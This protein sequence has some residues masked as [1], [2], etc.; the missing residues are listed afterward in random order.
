MLRSMWTSLALTLLCALALRT[1][2]DVVNLTDEDFA[3]VVDGSK[4]VLVEF[5][6]PWCGHCKNLAPEWK[7]AGETFQPSDDIV[8]AAVDATVATASAGK[9]GVKG[10]PTIKYFAKGET[11]PE[12]YKGGRTAADIVKWVNEKVGTNRRVKTVPSD[13]T[14]LTS[15]N[16]D[17][18]TG[19]KAALVEF[20]APWC[21]HCKTLAPKYEKLAKV[22]A[23]LQHPNAETTNF[24]N[25]LGT[26]TFSNLYI[27]V[28]FPQSLNITTINVLY[29]LYCANR[30]RISLQ[31]D[32]RY[33]LHAIIQLFQFLRRRQSSRLNLIHRI[34][35]PIPSPPKFSVAHTHTP[36]ASSASLCVGG[37]GSSPT[38]RV[39]VIPIYPTQPSYHGFIFHGYSHDK[40]I[41]L[42]IDEK[43]STSTDAGLLLSSLQHIYSKSMS[44]NQ[45]PSSTVDQIANFISDS[46]ILQFS[47]ETNRALY[48]FTTPNGLCGYFALYQ[49]YMRSS[50]RFTKSRD[51]V[52]SPNL[53][54]PYEQRLFTSFISTLAS[55]SP[56]KEFKEAIR[57]VLS[58][59]TVSFS[60][61][62]NNSHAFYN[63]HSNWL[64][65]SWL[66]DIPMQFE[67]S[68]FSDTTSIPLFGKQNEG[69]SYF[70]TLSYSS[71]FGNTFKYSLKELKTI[72]GK[73]NY[74]QHSQNHYFLMTSPKPSEEI[75]RLN[76]ALFDLSEVIFKYLQNSNDNINYPHHTLQPDPATETQPYSHT[77]SE[78]TCINL[79]TKLLDL[80]FDQHG[81]LVSLPN[82]ISFIPK[83]FIPKIRKLFNI[84][85]ETVIAYPHNDLNWKKFLLL[86]TVLFTLPKPN[87]NS[88]L[89]TRLNLL[90]D[91]DWSRFSFGSLGIS[92]Y[93]NPIPP[94]RNSAEDTHKQLQRVNKRIQKFGA[95]GDIS[96]VMK[97]IEQDNP[98]LQNDVIIQLLK[99][100]HPP[101]TNPLTL[102][103]E[104]C[105]PQ[106]ENSCESALGITSDVVRRIIRTRPRLR[107]PGI[108]KMNFDVLKLLVGYGNIDAP[109]ENIFVNNL[110][111]ILILILDDKILPEVYDHL[112]DNKLVGI[113]KHSKSGTP[114]VRP[115]G[116][117]TYLRK[118]CSLLFKRKLDAFN[119]N[120][121]TDIQY[122]LARNG[123]EIVIHSLR[124][125]LEKY[126][127]RDHFFADADNAFNRADR[128]IC[129]TE[130]SSHFPIIMPFL[131]R[132]YGHTSKGWFFSNPD[133]IPINS[134]QGFHQGCVLASWLFCVGMDPFY[135]NIQHILNN[136]G[137]VKCIIDDMNISAPFAEMIEAL[138]YV[139]NSGP[140]FGFHLKSS[141]GKYLLGRCG[142]LIEAKRRKEILVSYGLDPDVI[143]IHPHDDPTNSNKYGVDLLGTV[144]SPSEK[145][146]D[147]QLTCKL[148]EFQN[149][150][151][152]IKSKVFSSQLKFLC[153][154][155]S[156]SQKAAYIQRT[157]PPDVINKAFIP[158][159]SDLKRKLL[160]NILDRPHIDD[161][162]WKL[163]QLPI[164]NC[165]LGLGYCME[166]SH[167]A[168]IAS[169]YDCFPKYSKDIPGED[170][171]SSSL[172]SLLSYSRSVSWLSEISNTPDISI[173]TISNTCKS[174]NIPLQKSLSDILKPP[175]T[176]N[177]HSMYSS[178]A[179]IAWLNSLKCP[180]SGLWL[181][182]CPKTTFHTLSNNHFECALTLR[183]FLAQKTIIPFTKC[184][185]SSD[186]STI[187]IDTQGIHLCSGCHH[188]NVK[189]IVHNN[190][191]DCIN[192][193]FNHLGI[194]TVL[195]PINQFRAT[196]PDDGG[197]PDIKVLGLSDRPLLL[198]VSVTSPIPP[199]NPHS[200]SFSDAKI[201]L[202]QA[203]RRHQVKV[204]EYEG[205]SIE[206]NMDFLPIIFETTGNIHPDGVKL[207]KK[208]VHRYC[209]DRNAPFDPV[210]QFWMSFI[211]IS[212]QKT[213]AS[214]ILQRSYNINSRQHPT[215]QEIDDDKVLDFC[216]RR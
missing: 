166:T 128:Q 106:S 175:N 147:T 110:T 157:T 189:N 196:N 55:A 25:S 60:S 57:D 24:E 38:D 208:V 203:N 144:I 170:L 6:A 89:E 63:T 52:P 17:L 101:R 30:P 61:D 15:A 104:T 213:L 112:R 183:L 107:S 70:S 155:W 150:A 143:L 152:N 95:A 168:Y 165:G 184:T 43:H 7:I 82:P 32:S 16:F 31:L 154:K 121:F 146:L 100:K 160:E 64:H 199:N 10:Y 201:P 9:Y 41:A 140:K 159:F 129:L 202:R 125:S 193:T 99:E 134:T 83:K 206:N 51:S 132:L 141:K 185:C 173:T 37:G 138:S 172:P 93:I 209:K 20:Y 34:H 137:F 74:F 85:M 176:Q 86:P 79:H 45:S 177:T 111:K 205:K 115:I 98:H 117:G 200:L 80:R 118:I 181:K 8:I 151:D 96:Q 46:K 18:A 210:W 67:I 197:R 66:K 22:F 178:P 211:S 127:E 42:S 122:G 145:Y 49:C 68:F 91:D 191:R 103:T 158:R 142:S 62:S 50:K 105:Q 207:F 53:F 12:D 77:A 108:D 13:V 162:T 187:T 216:D 58:W 186:H 195:E 4:N 71:A 97:V 156:F 167:T 14:T 214:C 5:Y 11:E 21:G 126:P 76:E 65:S 39:E 120:H 133:A 164:S 35:L 114:D 59:I 161:R 136:T 47:R 148:N 135:K 84:V 149:T 198:D 69:P 27:S 130:V 33:R 119:N 72:C 26:P 40:Q 73:P 23:A 192:S 194:Q 153:L 75:E 29:L 90:L 190:L 169:I 212:F 94:S 204:R 36:T 44:T 131:R 92:S 182:S 1:G 78:Q 174:K 163:A 188:D 102:S 139:K 116:M 28:S 109:D 123:C 113:P 54:I 19:K 2:A 180:E 124:S 87:R 215:K 3:S 56:N 171:L 48:D 179:E 81:H 88:I